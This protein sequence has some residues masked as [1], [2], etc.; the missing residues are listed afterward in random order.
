MIAIAIPQYRNTA[1]AVTMT[2]TIISIVRECS[3][4][5]FSES[6]KICLC[7]Q[8]AYFSHTKLEPICMLFTLAHFIERR[9]TWLPFP[10]I[11][12][13]FLCTLTAP[14]VR[15]PGWMLAVGLC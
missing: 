4:F 8:D 1:I 7:F 2:K 3:F 11:R 13:V 14:A 10:K 5:F 6:H 15:M 9:R 12:R